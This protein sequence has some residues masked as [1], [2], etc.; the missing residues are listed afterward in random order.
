MKK[1]ILIG[2][3]AL[4]AVFVVADEYYT[5]LTLEE[6]SNLNDTQLTSW[7]ATLQ[8][9]QEEGQDDVYYFLLNTYFLWTDEN[10]VSWVV[11]TR[12]TFL[13]SML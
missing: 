2:L 5:P 10:D 11:P 6:F 13:H 4:L 3:V 7:N 9:I 8:V 12:A 1:I